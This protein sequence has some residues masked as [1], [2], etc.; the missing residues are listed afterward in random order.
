MRDMTPP[1]ASPPMRPDQFVLT[2]D[3]YGGAGQACAV[4]EAAVSN[5][6]KNR[7]YSMTSSGRA[8]WDWRSEVDYDGSTY[9]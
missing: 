8:P 6:S 9:E 7:R 2:V 4:P 5:R 3:D 1:T